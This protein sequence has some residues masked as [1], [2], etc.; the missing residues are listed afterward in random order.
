MAQDQIPVRKEGETLNLDAERHPGSQE[1]SPEDV[2]SWLQ[3][4]KVE[5]I[6]L[7]A[8]RDGVIQKVTWH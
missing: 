5:A 4:D 2:R 7:G 3:A 1:A 6:D 8:K